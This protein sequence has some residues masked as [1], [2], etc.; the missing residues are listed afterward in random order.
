MA[1]IIQLKRGTGATTSSHEPEEGEPVFDT[2]TGKLYI[3]QDGSTA[4]SAMTAINAGTA[5]SLAA[6]NLTAGDAAVTLAT[7]TGNITIDAQGNDTDII[8]KGTDDSSD[9]TFLTIDGS[10]AGHATFN[11]KVTATGFVIGSADIGEA[12][13]EILDGASVSTTELNYLDGTTLGTAVASKVLA[14]DS[15]KDLGTLRNLTIDGTFSD[16]NYTFDTSGNVSGL[17]TVGCGVITQSGAT[18]AATYSPIA[19]GSSIVTTGALN[20]G[21]ITSGFGNIDNGSSTLDTG[22]LTATTITGVG[23]MTVTADDV[24]FQNSAANDPLVQIK[25]TTNDTAGARL[26][27]VKDKGAAGADNDVAGQIEFYA[28]D[29]NQDNILFAKITAQVAD[30]SNGA[31][32]GKLSLGVATHDGEFQ[33]GLILT[34]GSAEDEVDVTIGNGS[35][36]LVTAAGDLTVTGDLIVSGDTTTVNTATLSVEDP[37]IY[38][39]NGASGTPTVDIGLIGERGSSTNVGIIWDESADVWS[40]ITTADTGTTAGDIS[41]S[42]YANFRAGTITSDDGFAGD[43]TGDVTGN[44]STAT[45][46]ATGRTING[47]TF[48]GTGNITITAA[49]STLSDTVTVAKGGTGATSLTDGGILVGSGTGAITALAV[50]ADGEMLVGDGTTDPVAESGATL[51]ASIGCNPVT[52]SSSITTLGTISTGTWNGSVIASA[53]LDADTAHLTTTQTFTGAKTFTA[54]VTYGAD[55][56]GVDVI[57]YGA[58]TGKRMTWDESA[59]NLVF[60]GGASVDGLTLDGGSFT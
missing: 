40:A 49:G 26:R 7:T 56:T 39:A 11:N 8:F 50:L 54:G 24:I 14:V 52:G 16:G 1:N 10:D 9:T 4:L 22:A 21:S 43:L 47:T 6:D 51:R 36:S 41:I 32:G 60:T 31:E 13:L 34:D 20:S 45:A 57:F 3:S 37:L 58:S 5:S 25:N 35:S 18:L 55:D 30:A 59:D 19:G 23:D 44:A 33:N 12:E 15:N 2:G 46:L 53:Y 29:D 38:M 27:F 28:D 17:G 48:D 42:D